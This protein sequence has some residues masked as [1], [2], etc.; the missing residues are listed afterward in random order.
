MGQIAVLADWSGAVVRNVKEDVSYAWFVELLNAVVVVVVVAALNV[1]QSAGMPIP[2]T[3]PGW[4]RPRNQL[5]SRH[6]LLF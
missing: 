1:C 6:L 2:Q 3:M 4:M 5:F